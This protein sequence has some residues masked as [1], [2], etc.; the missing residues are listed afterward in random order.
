MSSFISV[1]KFDFYHIVKIIAEKIVLTK[2]ARI[3]VKTRKW[4]YIYIYNRAIFHVFFHSHFP[5]KQICFVIMYEWQWQ[6]FPMMIFLFRLTSIMM[7]IY[8]YYYYYHHKRRKKKTRMCFPSTSLTTPTLPRRWP[9]FSSQISHQRSSQ[10]TT[11]GPYWLTN[12][13]I[14][15][16][17]SL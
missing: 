14:S 8:Y 9:I 13:S 2:S 16:C 10:F 7:I 5:S 12:S 11:W 15:S 1:F 4:K 6:W 17:V 3:C